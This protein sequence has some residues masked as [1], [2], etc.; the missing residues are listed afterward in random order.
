MTEESLLQK[1]KIERL[2]AEQGITPVEYKRR[3]EENT[4]R[5]KGM[6]LS[7][8]RKEKVKS[9]AMKKGVSAQEYR[10]ECAERSAKNKGFRNRKDYD[11]AGKRAKV[12]G[13]TKE[14]YCRM[15]EKDKEGFYIL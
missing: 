14:Q 6:T 4:A 1:Q 15:L 10:K 7:E 5:N 12:L 13:I 2:A 8:Y 11:K 9:V 3:C